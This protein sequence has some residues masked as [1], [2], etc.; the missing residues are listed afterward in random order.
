AGH[1]RPLAALAV[2]ALE[3][4]G[5]ID[6][7]AEFGSRQVGEP[8][9]VSGFHRAVSPG[10]KEVA[11]QTISVQKARISAARVSTNWLASPSPR[12]SGGSRRTTESAV[13]LISR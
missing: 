3:R 10:D 12:I 2:G 9:K 13:T 4:D 1:D 11:P 7:G 6:Q 5:V 8:E